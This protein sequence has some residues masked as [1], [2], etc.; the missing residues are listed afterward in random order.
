MSRREITARSL[1]RRESGSFP[2]GRGADLHLPVATA[3]G[4]TLPVAT[5]KRGPTATANLLIGICC[6]TYAK[7]ARATRRIVA[8]VDLLLDAEMSE[9]R[10][11]AEK[12]KV[13]LLEGNLCYC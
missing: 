11:W 10:L 6:G 5:A 8:L 7:V 13:A 4:M 9:A 1:R 12:C 2:A 3:K